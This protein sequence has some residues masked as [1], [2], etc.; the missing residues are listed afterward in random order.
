MQSPRIVAYVARRRAC[1]TTCSPPWDW[2]IGAVCKY[3]SKFPFELDP[4]SINVGVAQP[5]LPIPAETH[6]PSVPQ[7]ATYSVWR[8]TPFTQYSS[9][10]SA[11][12]T[13]FPG[14]IYPR[15]TKPLSRP[16]LLYVSFY[17]GTHGT[18]NPTSILAY[19]ALLTCTR[20]MLTSDLDALFWEAIFSVDIMS[21]EGLSN[22]AA[23]VHSPSKITVARNLRNGQAQNLID[24]IDQV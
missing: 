20:R 13:S 24:L 11:R 9:G 10:Y 23:L 7:Q 5:R 18:W 17:G 8:P 12:A 14:A 19:I 4:S 22:I 15:P 16:V 1:D 3:F 2:L 21:A 6:S